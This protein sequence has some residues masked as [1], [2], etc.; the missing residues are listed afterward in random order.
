MELKELYNLFIDMI[1]KRIPFNYDIEYYLKNKIIDPNYDNGLLIIY[2]AFYGNIEMLEILKKYGADITIREYE[3]LLLASQNGHIDCVK[4]L[5]TNDID[6]E[7][8]KYTSS[9]KTLNYI[10]KCLYS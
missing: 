6:I 4:L 8:F 3:A 9:Y 1:F 2:C 7:K 5:L 10:K